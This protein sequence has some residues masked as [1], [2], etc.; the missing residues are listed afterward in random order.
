MILTYSALAIWKKIKGEEPFGYIS[1]LPYKNDVQKRIP[2]VKKA[3][4]LL[5][6]E[7]ETDLSTILDEVIPWIAS[8]IEVGGI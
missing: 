4:D 1:D 2:C 7:A 6:F 5:N 3:K 8:Q